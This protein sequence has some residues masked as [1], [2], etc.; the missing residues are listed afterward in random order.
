MDRKENQ[1][2]QVFRGLS[3][4]LQDIVLH[5]VLVVWHMALYS[6]LKMWQPN[7]HNKASGR[8]TTEG[9]KMAVFIKHLADIKINTS[10]PT[11]ILRV[12]VGDIQIYCP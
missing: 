2:F 8:I 11:Q 10:K 9:R 4:L 1:I 7:L 6:V 3:L 5:L 12:I